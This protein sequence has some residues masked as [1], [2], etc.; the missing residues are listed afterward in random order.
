MEIKCPEPK[1]VTEQ[2][3]Q[4]QRNKILQAARKVFARKGPSATMDDIAAEASISHGLAYLYFDSK[5]AILRALIE[6]PIQQAPQVKQIQDATETPGER[7]ARNVSEFVASRRQ[8]P[9]FYQLLDRV[10][11][12]E[13]MPEDFRKVVRRRA[14]VLRD[15]LRQLI[16]EGQATGEVVAGNP[17]QLLSPFRLYGWF[18][19]LGDL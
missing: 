19:P 17:D 4:K 13:N 8:H 12:D 16:V 2:I 9:H 15:S 5:E 14:R 7:L 1:K 10:L 3:R 18:D 11:R 6:Q